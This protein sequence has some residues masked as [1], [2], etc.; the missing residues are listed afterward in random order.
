MIKIIIKKPFPKLRGFKECCQIFGGVVGDSVI[1]FPDKPTFTKVF[2]FFRNFL[3][4]N[5]V[6]IYLDFIEIIKER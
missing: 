3:P 5:K 2:G 4:L 6:R 1:M